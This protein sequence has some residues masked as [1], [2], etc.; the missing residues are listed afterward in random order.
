MHDIFSCKINLTSCQSCCLAVQEEI[1]L[2]LSI[3]IHFW[4]DGSQELGFT[5]CYD[6][7]KA[8]ISPCPKLAFYPTV[9]YAQHSHLFFFLSF[10]SWIF[11]SLS[12]FLSFLFFLFLS[13]YSPF[14]LSMTLYVLLIL[15]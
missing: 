7:R 13:C 2:L 1:S 15:L 9:C 12:L 14:P 10:A 6:G 4:E 3:F 8:G 5:F 11:F